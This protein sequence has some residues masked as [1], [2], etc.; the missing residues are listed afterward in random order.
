M[1]ESVCILLTYFCSLA[2]GSKH[3]KDTTSSIYL[4]VIFANREILQ[5]AAP[6]EW[7]RFGWHKSVSFVDSWRPAELRNSM[8]VSRTSCISCRFLISAIVYKVKII[9]QLEAIVMVTCEKSQ[10]FFA[11]IESCVKIESAHVFICSW[12]SFWRTITHLI[13]SDASVRTFLCLSV[14][15]R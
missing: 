9:E 5:S 2:T 13:F 14:N 10:L 3:S 1:Q 15:S 8:S 4:P 12:D 6:C 11:R 7:I